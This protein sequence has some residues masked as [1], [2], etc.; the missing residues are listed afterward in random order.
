MSD[1]KFYCPSCSA[2][3]G[4][5]RNASG[6]KIKCPECKTT[7]QVPKRSTRGDENKNVIQVQEDGIGETLKE[8]SEQVGEEIE[9]IRDAVG[10]LQRHL[11]SGKNDKVSRSEFD[12]C[13]KTVMHLQKNETAS[14]EE[15]KGFQKDFKALQKALEKI[16]DL[17]LGSH[18]K[19]IAKADDTLKDVKDKLQPLTRGLSKIEKLEETIKALSQEVSKL[20]KTDTLQKKVEIL[21]TKL[22]AY[23]KQDQT[24]E[25]KKEIAT[26]R[27]SLE[28]VEKS[29]VRQ[30]KST[31]EFE[32]SLSEM[33]K[34]LKAK[35]NQIEKLEKSCGKFGAQLKEDE[36]RLT[37]QQKAIE[38]A[39][40]AAEKKMEEI[41]KDAQKIWGI[42]DARF[43]EMDANGPSIDERLVKLEH[44]AHRM[45]EF[46]AGFGT[47]SAEA[48]KTL[49]VR[50]E[51]IINPDMPESD[52]KGPSPKLPENFDEIVF[53]QVN[54]DRK[55][56]ALEA[57]V[58]MTSSRV[59]II[60]NTRHEI[61]DEELDE[62]ADIDDGD[63]M[64]E[65]EDE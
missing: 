24:S 35:D 36:K 59:Q 7:I 55:I 33:A 41:S 63:E 62:D 34:Q 51:E 17:N 21:T 15:I 49:Q 11:T 22:E 64:N 44:N 46:A 57:L 29:I 45:K 18:E 52:R 56:N 31:V 47:K 38:K 12:G 32:L 25:L 58:K 28:K 30:E 1:I 40:T 14:K 53:Q 65:E 9:E 43:G 23:Q 2:K 5:N 54:I 20:Q 3:L 10:K 39:H 4:I 61:I 60:E 42:I 13:L 6:K 27:I 48:I 50:I 37:A 26:Y 8:F 19:Q 16:K